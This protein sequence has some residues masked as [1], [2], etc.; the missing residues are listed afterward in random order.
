[1]P[2]IRDVGIRRYCAG[3][4]MSFNTAYPLLTPWRI[5]TAAQGSGAPVRSLSGTHLPWTIFHSAF[6]SAA[7]APSGARQVAPSSSAAAS[8]GTG[9]ICAISRSL[10]IARRVRSFRPDVRG[11]DDRPPFCD[12]RLLQ[13]AERGRGLLV[14][15]RNVLAEVGEA[16][17]RGGIG[18]GLDHGRVELC[19]DK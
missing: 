8:S 10:P 1:M 11:L 17:T 14:E 19:D 15:G 6:G 2:E 13:R 18:E 7:S 12:L 3:P 5:W 4:T 9:L 16:G